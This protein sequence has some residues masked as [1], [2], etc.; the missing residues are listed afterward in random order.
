ML[1][2]IVPGDEYFNEEDSTFETVGDVELM[3]EHS[4]ISLSKWESIHQKPFLDKV[5]KTPEEIFDYIAT[6]ILTDDYPSD[7]LKRFSK[8]DFQE[9]NAYIESTQSA[10]TFG[11]MPEQGGR[12]ETI[13][14]ELIYYWMVAFTIPFECE[15]WH[16]NRLFALIKI[17]NIKNSPPKKMS[18]HEAAHRNREI[19]AA[20]RAQYNTKG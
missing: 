3:L 8:E 15:A 20:R 5:D 14:S 1:K 11:A 17:C 16:L 2:I 9:I 10:T 18:R 13:T 7:I 6:M 19:N 12:G 4:L